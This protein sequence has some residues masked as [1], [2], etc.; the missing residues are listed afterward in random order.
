MKII[1]F[2]II[3]LG[4]I[5]SFAENNC[6][7]KFI[8]SFK[9]DPKLTE[10]PILEDSVAQN[11]ITFLDNSEKIDTNKIYKVWN[12]T[13][14]KESQELLYDGCPSSIKE[15][16]LVIKCFNNWVLSELHD[17]DFILTNTNSFRCE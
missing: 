2:I 3:T 5:Q 4:S 1:F 17:D 10:Q 8:P 13:N 9:N 14:F 15:N 12:Y 6:T 11:I 7:F 16:S